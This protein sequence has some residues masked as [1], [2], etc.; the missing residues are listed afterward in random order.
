MKNL[1]FWERFHNDKCITTKE[2][3]FHSSWDWL[4]PTLNKILPICCELDE[5]E[6]Y[7][8]IT[9]QIPSITDTFEAVVN[10]IKWYNEN[11]K[12]S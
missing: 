11:K 12:T 6:R 10:F 3:K 9:D 7:W 4:I 2:C 5:M 1:E 8:I